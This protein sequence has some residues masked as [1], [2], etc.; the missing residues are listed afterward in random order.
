MSQKELGDGLHHELNAALRHEWRK[1][2]GLHEDK[3]YCWR[4][5]LSKLKGF[6]T[7]SL[8]ALLANIGVFSDH[9]VIIDPSGAL[10]GGTAPG[11]RLIIASREFATKC[12]FVGLPDI[13]SMRF[14]R[15]RK[16]RVNDHIGLEFELPNQKGCVSS[17][18]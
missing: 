13:E 2:P 9:V 5:Y 16:W 6:R 10:G 1:T 8:E 18:P 15:P 4:R 17:T 3:V 11:K 12:I 7:T 14:R